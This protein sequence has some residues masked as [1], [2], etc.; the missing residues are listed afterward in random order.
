MRTKFEYGSQVYTKT[1][2]SLKILSWCIKKKK[3]K[4]LYFISDSTKDAEDE[5]N[6]TE[7]HPD[8]LQSVFHKN[9]EPEPLV[10]IVNNVWHI[11]HNGVV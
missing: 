5:I 8:Y 10:S 9:E 1:L 4:C 3:K 6:T 7:L 11:S 2:N